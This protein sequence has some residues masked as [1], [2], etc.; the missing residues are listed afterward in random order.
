MKQRNNDKTKLDE[1]LKKNW[2]CIIRPYIDLK[3]SIPHALKE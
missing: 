1:E 2:N 3:D